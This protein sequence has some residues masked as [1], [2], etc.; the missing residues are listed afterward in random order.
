M[1]SADISY[2]DRDDTVV[3]MHSLAL[4]RTIWRD[5]TPRLGSDRCLIA[6]D[7]P[8]HG[9]DP[10]GDPSSVETM[11]DGVAELLRAKGRTGV[12][13]LGMS[14]GG[15]VA[16]AL[17]IRHPDL[18]GRLGLIDTTGWYGP[19]A[20]AAWAQRANQAKEKGIASLAG[21]QLDRWFTEAFRR[22]HPETGH[23]LLEIFERNDLSNYV[24]SCLALGAMDLRD[25]LPQISVPV[26]IVVGE[27]DQATPPAHAYALADLVR[28][29]TVTVL[30]DCKHLSAIERP[31]DVIA[32]LAGVL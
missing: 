20:P 30:P 22:D 18:V 5:F 12:T 31:D 19:D 7:L 21:F 9:V 4:D 6:P 11:A 2:E 24:A 29:A 28:Q 23:R 25:R 27:L 1:I 14:L 26:K 8:G 32:G 17:T 16:Q 3:L 10:Q 15:S 13:L